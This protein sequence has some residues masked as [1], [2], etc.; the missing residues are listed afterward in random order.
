MSLRDWFRGGRVERRDASYTDSLTTALLQVAGGGRLADPTQTAA[1]AIAALLYSSA[2]ASG[3]WAPD[4]RLRSALD[5]RYHRR[6]SAGTWFYAVRPWPRSSFRWTGYG[7]GRPVRGRSSGRGRTRASGPI[8]SG[9]TGRAARAAPRSCRALR[10]C[11][12]GVG[13]RQP[14]PLARRVAAGV[15]RAVRSGARRGRADDR[16]RG[17]RPPWLHPPGSDE[18]EAGRRRRSARRIAARLG[19]AEGQAHAHRNDGRRMG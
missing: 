1:A 17:E 18:S 13:K 11:T 2:L 6:C 16:G 5:R 8:N 14:R 15:G 10:C 19:R 3:D 12:S 4:G 7:S 9:S